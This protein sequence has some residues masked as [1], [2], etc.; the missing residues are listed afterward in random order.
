MDP[1]R[2]EAGSRTRFPLNEDR[3]FAIGRLKDLI[4][5]R[6][7]GRA[8]A[9]HPREDAVVKLL[10][11][12]MVFGHETR[13]FGPIGRIYDERIRRFDCLSWKASRH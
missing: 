5:Q 8:V 4:S 13:T 11:Q 12:P 9:D 2:D 1:L 7:H 3:E 6:L 10:S